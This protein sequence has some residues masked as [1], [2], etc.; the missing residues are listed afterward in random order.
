[1][2]LAKPC[3]LCG[4]QSPHLWCQL[5]RPHA[6][7][8]MRKAG[9]PLAISYV[10]GLAQKRDKELVPGPS[11]ALAGEGSS[12]VG[13]FWK[14]P[15]E[16]WFYACSGSLTRPLRLR[17][18]E[19]QGAAGEEPGAQMCW[20]QGRRPRW[21]VLAGP[22]QGRLPG[23]APPSRPASHLL[24]SQ[25]FLRGSENSILFSPCSSS[26]ASAWRWPPQ[27]QRQESPSWLQ[28]LTRTTVQGWEEKLQVL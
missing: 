14:I 22:P 24:S 3:L 13:W 16:H 15:E 18:S 21:G 20:R 27:P 28:G 25:S 26:L 12:C 7:L 11:A 17:G 1:M 2:I 10:P 8:S 9:A 5:V 4:P 6:P 23:P 19:A